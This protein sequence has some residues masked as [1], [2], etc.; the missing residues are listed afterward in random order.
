MKCWTIR[1][2]LGSDYTGNKDN[3]SRSW[4]SRGCD[5][6]ERKQTKGR[7][8]GSLRGSESGAGGSLV[9]AFLSSAAT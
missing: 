2:S 8:K 3:R 1:D 7:K 6:K 9:E 5:R 4:C